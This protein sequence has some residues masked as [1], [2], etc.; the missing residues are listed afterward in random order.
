VSAARG[1]AGRPVADRL[2]GR[3]PEGERARPPD[4]QT[5]RCGTEPPGWAARFSTEPTGSATRCGMGSP[6]AAN[7][8]GRR[9]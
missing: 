3:R 4:G 2:S 7:P 1:R 9:R 8:A 6:G 5:D